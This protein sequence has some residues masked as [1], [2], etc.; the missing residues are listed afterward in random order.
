MNIKMLDKILGEQKGYIKNLG[1]IFTKLT[2]MKRKMKHAN[3][4]HRTEMN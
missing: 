2:C 1:V 3:F 4:K